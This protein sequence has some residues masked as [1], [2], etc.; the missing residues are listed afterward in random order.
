MNMKILAG[1]FGS[2]CAVS[3]DS[4]FCGLVRWSVEVQQFRS[5]A[6]GTAQPASCFGP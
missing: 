1:W 2:R 3:G 4:F 6:M 5:V